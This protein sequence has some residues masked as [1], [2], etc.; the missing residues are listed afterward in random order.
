M[1]RLSRI[2]CAIDSSRPAQAAFSQALALSGARHTELALVIAVPRSEPFNR[3]ARA[4]IA[5]IAA[6]RRAA[7]AAGVRLR[8]SVQ[9]GDPAGVILLHAQ[10]RH[11]DLIVL[12]TRGGPGRER[13]RAGS[14]ARQVTGRATCPV[15]VVPAAPAG[16]RG[17]RR[18]TFSNVV[19]PAD[20]SPASD[21]ALSQ[22][23]GV[24]ADSR[25]R[26]TL[27]HAVPGSDPMNRS[28]YH[29][30]V[31]E[32][33]QLMKREAWQRMQDSVPPGLRATTDVYARVVTGTPADQIVR[34]ARDIDADLIVMGVTSRGAVGRRLFGSTAVR[35]MRSAAC[36]VLAVP[37]RM[38]KTAP[39]HDASTSTVLRAA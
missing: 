18:G 17:E 19:C 38:Q 24:A 35:V 14:V 10:S 13:F 23:L 22:A 30:S 12:G 3:R 11:C 21:L 33:G 6:L 31:P 28:A 32:Y 2:L 5:L 27:V 25:G 36:P 20:F 26:L 8:V 16:G 7:D 1:K 29:F 15:L 34:L 39:L 37:G 4:R 9:H